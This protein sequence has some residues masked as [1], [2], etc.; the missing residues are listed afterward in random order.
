VNTCGHC[1][2]SQ[3][4]TRNDRYVI[5]AEGI[6]LGGVSDRGVAGGNTTVVE[7]R[8]GFSFYFIIIYYV[9][10]LHV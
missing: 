8:R 10:S 3:Q 7:G 6:R 4:H 9:V 1:E 5:V 2:H